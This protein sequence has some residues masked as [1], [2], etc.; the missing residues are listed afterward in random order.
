MAFAGQALHIRAADPPLAAHVDNWLRTH[1]LRVAELED[2]YAACVQLLRRPE[3]IADLAFIGADWLGPTELR[4]VQYVRDT[5]PASG[6]VVYANRAVPG[7]TNAPLR[8]VVAAERELIELL[9]RSPADLLRL[10]RMTGLPTDPAPRACDDPPGLG[11]A[12]R[13][14]SLDPPGPQRTIQP[15]SLAPAALRVRRG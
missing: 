6:I 4:I 1:R 15:E 9:S 10:L 14:R 12:A 3:E 8:R 2:A 5:W 11:C 13:V 7:L